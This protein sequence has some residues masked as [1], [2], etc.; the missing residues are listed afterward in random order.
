MSVRKIIVI[1]LIFVTSWAAPAFAAQQPPKVARIGFLGD[2]PTL[3]PQS[4]EAFRKGLRDLGWVEGQ[5]LVIEYR[6]AEGRFD[7]LS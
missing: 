1:P 2:R 6:W 7:R 3:L 5:N 4:S